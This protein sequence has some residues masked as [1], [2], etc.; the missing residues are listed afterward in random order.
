MEIIKY[1]GR[2]QFITHRTERFSTLEGAEMALQGGCRWVQLRMKGA[3]PDEILS[4]GRELRR[5]CDRADATLIVDDHVELAKEI[6]A[7]GVHLGLSDMPIAEARHARGEEFLSGG[8]ANTAEQAVSHYRHSADYI[9][10]GPF[11][12]TTTKEKLAPTLG[13]S[14]YKAIVAALRE[15]D[16]SIPIVAIGGITAQDIDDILATGVNGIALSGAILN[17]DDPVNMMQEIV[18]TLNT[19]MMPESRSKSSL[20]IKH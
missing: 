3:E 16:I 11:R 5:M 18:K 8:T 14:G 9:G 1:R 2:L 19:G 17:A 10:C 15:Q 4:T 13:L 7:D 12:F 6:K 20:N